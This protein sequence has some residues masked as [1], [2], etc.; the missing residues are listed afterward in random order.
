MLRLMY[1]N[2]LPAFSGRG[3]FHKTKNRSV[4]T[5]KQKKQAESRKIPELMR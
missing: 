2:A 4:M 5:K 1:L 3:C